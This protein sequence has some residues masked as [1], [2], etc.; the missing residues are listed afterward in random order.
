MVPKLF[1]IHFHTETAP[2]WATT[3]NNPC[4]TFKV[5]NCR[6]LKD[7]SYTGT[8]YHCVWQTNAEIG[9]RKYQRDMAHRYI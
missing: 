2:L 9:E 1:F 5:S 3:R 4:A 6:H 8:S 7:R